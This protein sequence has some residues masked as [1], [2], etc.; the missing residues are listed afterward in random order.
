MLKSH[1]IASLF[2]RCVIHSMAHRHCSLLE[3]ILVKPSERSLLIPQKT[4]EMK[5]TILTKVWIFIA[6]VTLFPFTDVNDLLNKGR[7]IRCWY[8]GKLGGFRHD[9]YRCG[10]NGN[11]ISQKPWSKNKKTWKRLTEPRNKH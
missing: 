5:A 3:T 6:I 7:G 8:P 9:I 1:S 11:T 4:N 10:F 2:S